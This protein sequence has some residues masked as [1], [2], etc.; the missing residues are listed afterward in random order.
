[1]YVIID[2]IARNVNN[3]LSST[4]NVYAKQK[5]ETTKF[6]QKANIYLKLDYYLFHF[7]V[8]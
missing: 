6:V 7:A 2:I 8:K 1:M 4:D 5:L 3:S